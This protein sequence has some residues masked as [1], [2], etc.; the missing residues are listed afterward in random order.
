MTRR[1]DVGPILVAVAAIALLVSLF[2]AWYGSATAWDVFELV[3]VL[4]AAA[5]VAA[6]VVAV[7]LLAPDASYLERRWL[8][9]L[10]VGAAVLVT[11]EIVDP[12]PAA[13]DDS[14]A[15]GAWIAFAS[16]LVM[17]VG[18]VMS[19]GR[20]SLAVA[21]EGKETRER[22]AV[23]DNRQDTTESAAV[24]PPTRRERD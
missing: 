5:A 4:L 23:V 17:V 7:G 8:P 9:I 11:A 10:V 19:F 1:F 2:L 14:A 15:T 24:T 21:V 12:P 13:P 20:V 6:I 16:A 18:A 22:V 3:D